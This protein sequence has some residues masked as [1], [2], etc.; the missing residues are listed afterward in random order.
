MTA[1]KAAPGFV[2][3]WSMYTLAELQERLGLGAHAWRTARKE[4]LPVRAIGGRKYALGRD[5]IEWVGS[6]QVDV[7]LN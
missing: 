2:D 3:Q 7:N 1:E 6:K 4:G 5:V